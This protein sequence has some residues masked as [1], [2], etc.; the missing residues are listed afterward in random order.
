MTE[1]GLAEI[2]VS[3]D[4]RKGISIKLDGREISSEISSLTIHM[5]ADG[6]PTG[7]IEFPCP[8]LDF[9]QD[10]IVKL[11]EWAKFYVPVPRKKKPFWL[12]RN[13]SPADCSNN[14]SV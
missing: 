12:R 6:L 8:T 11:P 13:K 7:T 5:P 2:R 9:N 10:A 4:E 3:L 14:Q 1:L